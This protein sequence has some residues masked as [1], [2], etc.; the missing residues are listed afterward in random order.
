MAL[1]NPYSQEKRL[2]GYVGVPFPSVE[3]RIVS[4][5]TENDVLVQGLEICRNGEENTVDGD[6]QVGVK[7]LFP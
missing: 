1:T 2:A 3:V 7:G 5:G 4:A 6:L